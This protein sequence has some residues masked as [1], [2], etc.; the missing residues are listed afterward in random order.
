MNAAINRVRI[1]LRC[2]IFKWNSILQMA[3]AAVFSHS[4]NSIYTSLLSNV[5]WPADQG[6]S[7]IIKCDTRLPHPA[8]SSWQLSC[9]VFANVR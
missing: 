6:I 2:S 5:R 3:A 1:Q 7:E 9:I 8:V 4:H